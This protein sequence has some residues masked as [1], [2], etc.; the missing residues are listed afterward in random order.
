MK[1]ANSVCKTILITGLAVAA[2]V[3]LPSQAQAQGKQA[4]QLMPVHTYE[5][6][7]QVEA[8]DTIV[9]TCPKCKTTY[10]QV[11]DKD[12]KTGTPDEL[13]TVGTHLCSSCDTKLVTTGMGK[14]AQNVLVHTCKVCGSEDAMCCVIKKGSLPTSGMETK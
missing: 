12:F 4:T 3:W 10:A 8:G 13:K 9:M 7:Q 6:L 11:V 1:T 14:Q 2:L 5:D